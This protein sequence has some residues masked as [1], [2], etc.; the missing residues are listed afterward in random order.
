MK[1]ETNPGIWDPDK[2]RDQV[3]LRQ[4]YCRKKE[5]AIRKGYKELRGQILALFKDKSS[6]MKRIV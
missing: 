6:K 3:N 5:E 1:F 2:V 4:G